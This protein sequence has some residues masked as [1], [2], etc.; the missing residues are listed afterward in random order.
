[1]MEMLGIIGGMGPEASEVF[2]ARINAAE[3]AEKDQDH[4]NI[5]LYSH[6]S[7]PDRTAYIL[8]GRQEELWHIFKQDIDMLKKAGITYLAVPCNTSHYFSDRFQKEMSGNFISMVDEAAAC[9]SLDGRRKIGILATDGTVKAG[10]YGKALRKLG[11]EAVYPDREDQKTIMSIIYDEIKKG[12]RGSISSFLT[13]ADHMKEKGCELCILACT[14]LSVLKD[15][16]AVLEDPF[17]LDAMDALS[18]AC[19]IKCGGKLKK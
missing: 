9:A 2:Y 4:I 18:R 16:Y 8:G 5:L 6:A 14:E 19:I 15:Q 11:C 17:Y 12:R 3:K 7:I 13:V 10:L 1:M